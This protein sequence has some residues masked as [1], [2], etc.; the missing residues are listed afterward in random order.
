MKKNAPAPN[1]PPE[2]LGV[3]L[4]LEWSV[5]ARD[6]GNSQIRFWY[7][8]SGPL[9]KFR[10]I[11][12]GTKTE[13]VPKDRQL[14]LVADWFIREGFKPAT[15]EAPVN[16]FLL[17][18]ELEIYLSKEYRNSPPRTI[19]PIRQHLERLFEYL[20]TGEPAKKIEGVSGLRQVSRRH[21]DAAW[22]K[23]ALAEI[24]EPGEAPIY[25]VSKTIKNMLGNI[26]K[27]FRWEMVREVKEGEAYLDKDPTLN[28]KM[29]TK[30]ECA[31]PVKQ[32]WEK[33]E[34]ADTLKYIP[35]A[36]TRDTLLM[37]RYCGG[38]DVADT[39]QL[40]AVHIGKAGKKGL[41]IRKLRAKSKQKS[42][43]EWIMIPVAEI[44]LPMVKAR[45]A[46]CS[47][48]EDFLFPW[49][50]I[51]S[52]LGGYSSGLYK[53]V[54]KARA[55]AGLPMKELKALRHTFATEQIEKGVPIW[56]VG[57]WLGHVKGSPITAQVYNLAEGEAELI[58]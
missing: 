45:L 28:A 53:R 40:Q 8:K 34:F 55:L 54:K 18:D 6:R 1:I 21:F 42:K 26:R 35:D 56:Q 5:Q 25:L 36:D 9:K 2:I 3:I 52:T 31:A 15:I 48:P 24:Q 51:H 46:Q 37:L 50:A 20:I 14:E 32:K 44:I 22:E 23:M 10:A 33:K 39:K 43:S 29:P 7:P 47:K 4:G 13:N 58:N 27:F 57:P 19:A 41:F 49:N 17:T 16:D 38:L 11:S 30:G 12:T